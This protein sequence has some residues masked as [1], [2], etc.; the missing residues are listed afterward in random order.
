MTPKNLFPYDDPQALADAIDYWL[1]NEE[2]KQKCLQNYLQLF[3]A[4]PF[5][6]MHE[7]D[8]GNAPF[9]RGAEGER[10]RNAERGGGSEIIPFYILLYPISRAKSGT[11][12]PDFFYGN[13]ENLYKAYTAPDGKRRLWGAGKYVAGLNI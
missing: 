6:R 3:K 9:R 12:V 7:T 1:E 4:F 5:G 13:Y 10:R 8:G 2:E 11:R